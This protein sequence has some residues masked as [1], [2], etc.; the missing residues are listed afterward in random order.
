MKTE[1]KTITP[2]LARELLKK[3]G[4]NRPLNKRH[5]NILAGQMLTGKWLFDGTPI[6]LNGAGQLLDGQHRLTALVESN[7]TFDFVVISG[8]PSESFKVMDTGKLRSAADS[9]GID[10]PHHAVLIADVARHLV[11]FDSH[12]MFTAIS[13]RDRSTFVPNS[14][15]YEYAMANLEKINASFEF[16]KKFKGALLQKSKLTAFHM[17]FSRVNV[18]DADLFISKFSTGLDLDAESPIY[19]LRQKLI[20]NSLS[21]KKMSTNQKYALIVRAWNK[22]RKKETVSNMQIPT[23][24]ELEIL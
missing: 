17:L 22:F 8:L 16:C 15:V 23:T 18:T 2:E 13:S 14:V 9:V 5:V 6:K 12:Q 7:Q 21:K 1:I 24:Y 10:V 11:N 3:N 19:I 20:Q 4:L